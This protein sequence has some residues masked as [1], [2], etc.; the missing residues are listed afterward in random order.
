VECINGWAE[1]QLSA[2]QGHREYKIHLI[3]RARSEFT[4]RKMAKLS[5]FT[6]RSREC[7]DEDCRIFLL[8]G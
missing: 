5:C 2:Q 6:G 1:V 7:N 3:N 4:T 8:A